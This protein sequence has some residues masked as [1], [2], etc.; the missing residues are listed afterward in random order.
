MPR[1]LRPIALEWP[2]A[3]T[4]TTTAFTLALAVQPRLLISVWA[5]VLTATIE[6]VVTSA[7]RLVRRREIQETRQTEASH[8][9]GF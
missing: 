7:V 9:V 4:A 8:A 6:H 2:T 1:R 5:P 3:V